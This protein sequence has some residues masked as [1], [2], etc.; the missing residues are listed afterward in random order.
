MGIFDRLK[1]ANQIADDRMVKAESIGNPSERGEEKTVAQVL[2]SPIGKEAV[3][4]ASQTL[5]KYKQGKANFEKKIIANEEWYKL[6][7]WESLREGKENQI[8][9]ASA[10]LF[11][12]IANKCSDLMDNFP[13]PNI[14]PREETDKAEAEM[15]SSIVPVMLEQNEFETTYDKVTQSKIKHGTG[16]YGVFWD[17]AKLNGLGDISIQRIDVLSL[18]WQPGVTDIQQS[19]NLFHVEL[20]DNNVLESQYPQLV[21]KLGTKTVDVAQYVYDDTID[22][23]D[24]SAVIDW[25]YKKQNSDGKTVLHF[26]KYVNDTVLFATEN[27]VDFSERGLYDHSEYPFIFDVLYSL[28]DTPVGFG[29]IDIG[30]SAQEYI[31]RGNQAILQNMLANTKPR[32]FARNDGSV[33]LEEY[34]DMTK[35]IVHVNGNL[36]ADT[37]Q[38]INGKPLSNAYI[39]VLHDKIDELKET[40]GNRDVSAGGTTSGVTAASAIAAL[41]EAGNK[42]S[43]KDTKSSYRAFRKVCLMVIELIRQFYDMPR[44]FRI[45]GNNGMMRF[46][47]YTNQN[48]KAQTQMG[49][50]GLDETIR[51]PLFDIEVTAEKKSP[52]TRMAQNEL[53][54]QFYSAGFFNPQMADQALSCLSMMDFDSKEEIIQRIQQNN[55]MLQQMMMLAQ[56]LDSAT[57]NT[58]GFAQN[59]AMQY[60]MTPSQPISTPTVDTTSKGN[61]VD[62]ARQQYAESITP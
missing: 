51:L 21:N 37:I 54:L 18:Y 53:A 55:G 27:E 22:T 52:Y 29:Y 56:M 47:S 60:G 38:P 15:L 6:R 28:E 44:Q 3:L 1:R 36:G 30:K 41:Q 49:V 62:K 33:N 34:A 12:C 39:Q 17:G 46:V 4:K 11:N 40:T 24:K 16:V 42:L 10:W 26:C 8:E 43:R 57:G 48:I 14:L 50:A 31:D 45:L 35:D 61:T 7:H 59:I 2:T 9:P 58:Q 23:T 5:Q 19:Q 25:Y 13:A 32:F 20:M